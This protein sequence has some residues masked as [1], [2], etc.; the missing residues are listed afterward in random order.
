MN[1]ERDKV[2]AQLMDLEAV[3][4]AGES[5]GTASVSSK[6]NL[7][8]MREQAAL[9]SG[10]KTVCHHLF[11]AAF[12][13]YSLLS[14][15]IHGCLSYVLFIAS[16]FVMCRSHVLN[17]PRSGGQVQFSKR[18]ALTESCAVGPATTLFIIRSTFSFLVNHTRLPGA[19][20][21]MIS[22]CERRGAGSS[23]ALPKQLQAP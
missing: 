9:A 23:A 13:I 16:V 14:V 6:A 7:W 18:A 12:H 15:L 19:L 4:A 3:F 20:L 21:V 10:E 5:G 17:T 1:P 2:R 11:M 8:K 22:L